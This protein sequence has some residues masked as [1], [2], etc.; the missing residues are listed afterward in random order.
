MI[1]FQNMNVQFRLN[2]IDY[3]KQNFTIWNY[4]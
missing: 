2:L 1:L 4:V 3:S